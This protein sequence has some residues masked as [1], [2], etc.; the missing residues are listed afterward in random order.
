MSV[1]G[2]QEVVKQREGKPLGNKAQTK[3]IGYEKE[4]TLQAAWENLHFDR[5]SLY[6]EERQQLRIL[7]P[8]RLNQDQGPDFLDAQIEIGSNRH[9]GH[10]ELHLK[11]DDWWRHG[12]HKDPH[13]DAVVLHV[14]L[15]KGKRPAMRTDGTSIP[16]LWLGARVGSSPP[17][18]APKSLP[19]I[20]IGR[21]HLPEQPRIWLETEGEQRL[22]LKSNAMENILAAQNYDWS[23]LLWEELA[24]A[25]GGPVN[26]SCFKR[27]A[28]QLPWALVRKYSHDP[29]AVEALLFGRSGMLEGRLLD[30]Y[31]LRLQS[32]WEFQKTKHCLS[33]IP[34]PFKFHRMH[35]AGFPT[36][37]M[38]QLAGLIHRYRPIFQLLEIGE[39]ERFLDDGMGYASAYW[40]HRYDFGNTMRNKGSQLGLD[41]KTR[42]V[43]N[44]LSPLA[45]LYAHLHGLQDVTAA[46]L[47]LL[48]TLPAEQNK[49]TRR[50]APLKLQAANILQSQGL[51][52]LYQGKC[53]LHHCLTCPIGSRALGKR[54]ADHEIESPIPTQEAQKLPV[55]D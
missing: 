38:A 28:Q 23:Q 24:S 10:V 22:L 27:F 19:C 47:E 48:Q 33:A 36:L 49:I 5:Q 3:P 16:E 17:R 7:H 39:I 30:D 50:F 55:I 44:V 53:S 12:H 2:K 40:A 46:F 21:L 43:V 32:Q 1:A 18:S 14:Y 35:P 45:I 51:I 29:I 13:Y 6:T 15:E 9:H 42:I 34:L 37:R 4:A 54:P 41:A 8:G 52:G 20:G 26:A 11:G 25:M 31:Q